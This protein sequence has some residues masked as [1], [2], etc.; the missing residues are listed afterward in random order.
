MRERTVEIIVGFFVLAGI[1][2]LLVLALKVSGLS[3]SVGGH[4]YQVTARF[5]NIGSLK[6][7]APVT[8]AGVRVGEVTNIY[9]DPATFKAIATLQINASQNKIPS[10]TSASIL[11]QGLLGANYISLN[12]GYSETFLKNGDRI[13]N[14]HP[15]IILENL[16]GQFLFSV[17]GPGK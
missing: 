11:T 2:A 17:K 1:L 12:P 6:P 7:R 3:M 5:D 9:L 13:Q 10:D 14:T 4:S 15:A 8:M 16:I